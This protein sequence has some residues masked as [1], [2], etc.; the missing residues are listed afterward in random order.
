MGVPKQITIRGPS[1][2]LT[3]RLRAV[4]EARGESM[5]TT[6]LRLLEE[7]LGVSERRAR[8]ERAATWSAEDAREFDSA[9][10]A[11]RVVDPEIWE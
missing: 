5:N 11:Q 3:H 1:E 7:A 2:A 4:S 9:L 10:D 8:L 6:I